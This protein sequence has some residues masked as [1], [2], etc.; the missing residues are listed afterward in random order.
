MI[1]AGRAAFSPFGDGNLLFI[2]FEDD[3]V[4]RK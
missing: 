2:P 1:I 4:W 3:R